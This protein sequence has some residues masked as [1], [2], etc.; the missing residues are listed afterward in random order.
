MAELRPYQQQ[1][2]SEVY[3][4][5]RE[6]KRSV[7]MQLPT[8]GG[9]SVIMSSMVVDAMRKGRKVLMLVHRKELVEQLH[10][11]MYQHGVYSGII[12]ADQPYRP[13]A[14]VQIASVQT[15]VRRMDKIPTRFDLMMT[16]ECFVEGTLVDG[17]PIET[18]NVGD[19][20]RSYNHNTCKVEYKRVT[21]V[22][23][24]DAPRVMI[25]VTLSTGDI[26]E[27]TPNHPFY[28]ERLGRYVDA[29]FLTRSNLLHHEQNHNRTEAMPSM[30]QDDYA[31]DQEPDRYASQREGL[32]FKRVLEGIL[33]GC[34][35]GHNGANESQVC[36]SS[37]EIQQPNDEHSVS[38]EDAGDTQVD[39]SQTE[40]SRGQRQTTNATSSNTRRSVEA[41]NRAH[42]TDWLLWPRR[43]WNS[44]ALQGRHR[45]SSTD[46]DNRGGRQFPL[47]AGAQTPRHKTSNISHE[48]RMVH[49]EIYKR[50][51][52]EPAGSMSQ[53]RKVYNLEVAD[54]HNYFVNDVLVHNCHHSKADSYR[55]IYQWQDQA[56]HVGVTA[57]PVRTNGQGFSDL[58]DEMAL[59]PSVKDLIRDGFLVQPRVFSSPLRMDLAQLRTTAGDYNDR[60]LFD[61]MSKRQITANVV[62]TWKKHAEGK[63]TCVFAVNVEH[64]KQI[65]SAYLEAGIR[66]AHV[67]AEMKKEDRERILRSFSK[68]DITVITNCDIISEGFDVPAI[69]CVQL[70]RPTKSL[71]KYLQC[72]G[73]ALRPMSGKDRAIILDHGDCVFRMGFPDDDRIWTLDG[74]K[75][76]P[77]TTEIMYQDASGKTYSPTE[78]PE[79][80]NDVELVEIDRTD[81]R[82]RLMAAYI[83]QAKPT[84]QLNWA[85][86]EFIKSVSVPT[87]EEI[88][89]FH[90]HTQFKHGWTHVQMLQFG[91]RKKPPTKPI[92][93]KELAA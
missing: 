46:V 93:E 44:I 3:S 32:L 79:E 12:M 85:W 62:E 87:R 8:G 21:H 66:A 34:K 51:N 57:T 74:I 59:G 53:S 41:A 5:L 38:I 16:D 49:V 47:I 19:M 27:C 43:Y 89:E 81:Y 71:V 73:R 40:G 56:R 28:C 39:R 68:G 18:I 24:N 26:I 20:V 86:R 36:V 2:K 82:K 6:G 50:R 75:P 25:R 15:I 90:K 61:V 54:H 84:G 91:Y 14:D 48:A 52:T 70:V 88:F 29:L 17:R 42:H 60:D 33:R 55:A 77:V 64:S 37:H 23:V 7:M 76:R 11:H 65:C 1:L 22:F 4:Y 78:L 31:C 9:K 30:R 58:F 67:S 80:V 13:S 45:G 72:C 83:E 63:R 10:K 69:E 35:Q 92:V